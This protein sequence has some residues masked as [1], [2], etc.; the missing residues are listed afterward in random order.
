M[1][2]E[3]LIVTDVGVNEYTLP[4][5]GHTVLVVK[6]C[7]TE[8]PSPW[9]ETYIASLAEILPNPVEALTVAIP[10]PYTNSIILVVS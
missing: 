3:G 10:V 8:A 5:A 9:V 4:L 6:F 2:H 7:K 1:L